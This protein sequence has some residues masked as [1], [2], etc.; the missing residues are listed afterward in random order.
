MQSFVRN[1][2]FTQRDFFTDNGISTL[3]SAANVAGNVCEECVY[4]P[5]AVILPEVHVA[6]VAD[7]KGAND[8]VLFRRKDARDISER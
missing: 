8:V 5:W 7:L 6:V 1:P 3:L 2:L 4:D